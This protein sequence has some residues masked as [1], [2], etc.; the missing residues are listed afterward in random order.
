MQ[1]MMNLMTKPTITQLLTYSRD[2]LNNHFK[3]LNTDKLKQLCGELYI[4]RYVEYN[5][6]YDPI[7]SLISSHITQRSS[8]MVSKI[9]MNPTAYGYDKKS[10]KEL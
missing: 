3:A 9:K 5:L 1:Y 2:E 4:V 8:D 6:D 7:Y 10:A